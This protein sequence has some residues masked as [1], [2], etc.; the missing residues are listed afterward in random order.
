[1]SHAATIART[2]LAFVPTIVEGQ[3]H[4]VRCACPA[5]GVWRLAAARPEPSDADRETAAVALVEEA[6]DAALR[7]SG[8]RPVGV[9]A[10]YWRDPYTNHVLPRADA[11]ELCANDA[12][13]AL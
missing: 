3:D 9:G 8:W 11:L 4:D 12:A 1:M 2:A 6:E 10:L 5:C 13:G 7:A